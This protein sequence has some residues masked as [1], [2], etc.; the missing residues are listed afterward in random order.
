MLVDKLT[1]EMRNL[2][3]ELLDSKLVHTISIPQRGE[4][5]YEGVIC[6]SEYTLNL[7]E[8]RQIN[9]IANKYG[10]E[11]DYIAGAEDYD[12]KISI[13]KIEEEDEN[14]KKKVSKK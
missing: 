1:D 14:K 7:E 2:I 3:C 12:I 6:T 5:F 4:K 9:A 8:I 11:I 10:F 13:F